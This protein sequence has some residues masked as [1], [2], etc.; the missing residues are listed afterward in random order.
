[1]YIHCIVFCVGSSL[2]NE[3]ITCS[4]SS[5]GVCACACERERERQTERQREASTVRWPRPKMKPQ[6]KKKAHYF[7]I[8]CV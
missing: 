8:I 5:C 3:L 1:M 4:E 6:E 7:V 2:C